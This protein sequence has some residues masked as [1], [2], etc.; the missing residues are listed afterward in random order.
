MPS[1][2]AVPLAIIANELVTNAYNMR[3]ATAARVTSNVALKVQDAIEL[4]VTDNG[5]GL[6]DLQRPRGLVSRIIALLTQ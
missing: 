5:T 3:S 1:T 4:S 6:K 2:Q